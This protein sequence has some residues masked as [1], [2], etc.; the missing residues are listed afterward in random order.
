M[1]AHGRCST[2]TF[3]VQTRNRY[4]TTRER[5]TNEFGRRVEKR[6]Q[7]DKGL[8]GISLPPHQNKEDKRKEATEGNQY[9]QTQTPHP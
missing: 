2:G 7:G 9:L 4:M 1:T 5:V 8:P 6:R 3:R